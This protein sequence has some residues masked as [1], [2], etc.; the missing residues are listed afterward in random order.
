MIVR[1]P[2]SGAVSAA[3]DG[4][5]G[6]AAFALARYGAQGGTKPPDTEA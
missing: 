1:A 3:S 6:P 4:E 2:R 5:G